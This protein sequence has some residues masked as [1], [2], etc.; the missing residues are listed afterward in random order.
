[1]GVEKMKKTIAAFLVALTLI[2]LI[3]PIAMAFAESPAATPAPVPTFTRN[4]ADITRYEYFRI[5]DALDKLVAAQ[6]ITSAQEKVILAA[7]IPAAV[8]ASARPSHSPIP[9]SSPNSQNSSKPA[10]PMFAFA[11]RM[12]LNTPDRVAVITTVLGISTDDFKKAIAD[13]KTLT[14]L[15]AGKVPALISALS[16]FDTAQIDSALASGKITAQTSTRLKKNLTSR[17]T[18]E[19]T[20]VAR[21]A[22]VR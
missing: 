6:T 21:I 22:P 3:I 4:A 8:S 2:A 15:A 16:A 20:R 9:S 18:A 1:V 5:Q 14:L 10:T 7:I 13:R 17:I 11:A 19:V 12:G